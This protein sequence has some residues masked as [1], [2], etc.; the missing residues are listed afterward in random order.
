ME[1]SVSEDQPV[2]GDLD[3][4]NSLGEEHSA[5]ERERGQRHRQLETVRR[6][7]QDVL[8]KGRARASSSA[9]DSTDG[10]APPPDTAAPGDTEGHVLQTQLIDLNTK[11]DKVAKLCASKETRIEGARKEAE[12]FHKET[13][14]LL[15]WLADA[16]RSLRYQGS[17]PDEENELEAN[18]EQ[19]K[20]FLQELKD[21]EGKLHECLHLGNEILKRCHP[22]AVTTVKH[23]L[24]ILQARWEEV[25]SWAS[26]RENKMMDNLDTM[27]NQANLVE[28]LMA[29]LTGAEASLLAQEAQPIPENIPILEQLLH[30]H[31]TFQGDISERQPEVD[32]IT[33]LGRKKTTTIVDGQ[34]S[35]PRSSR[36]GQRKT[37]HKG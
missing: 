26:S 5:L 30:D 36:Y 8:K 2:H 22:D 15:E 27:R 28:Q 12:K 25:T 6:A 18:L 1:P 33:S 11:W 32:R 10:A 9:S 3:T 4:V 20:V 34:S 17:L 21:Q 37:P 23:W 19:H 31:D 13:H 7:A 16:E 24:T 14:M 35:I 29:W